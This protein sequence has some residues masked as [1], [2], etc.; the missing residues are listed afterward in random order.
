[1]SYEIGMKIL[2]LEWTERVGRTEYCDHTAL[3][4]Y[5]TGHDPLSPDQE[6]SYKAWKLFYEWAEYDILWFSHDGPVDWGALGRI[7]DMGHAVYMEGGIDYRDKIYCPFKTP[8]EVLSFYAAE[9]YGLPDIKERAKFF[10]KI[11]DEGQKA[12]PSLVFPGGYYKTLVSGCIQ[13]FGWEMFLLAIGTDPVRFGEYVLEGFSELTLANIKAWAKTNIKVFISHDDMVWTEGAF[14][15][16]SW[17][18]KYIFPRYKKL[19]EPLKEKGIKVLFCSDGD[20]TEFVDDLAEAGADGFIFEPLTSLDYIVERYGKTHIIVGNA[21]CRIL[22]F[23][24]K[25]DVEKEVKRCIEKAKHCPGF[26]MA[27]GNHIPSNVPIENALYYFE[28]VREYG[29][30]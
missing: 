11:Y 16:P 8:E 20:F 27:V 9:E 28:L 23:G 14:I 15:H 17:Y 26:I 12:Y 4:R 2:N 19:W 18:R 10:Q 3:V 1:M 25:E 5:I 13:S 29:R 24:T 22:T 6:E 21:D 7:T 30:R